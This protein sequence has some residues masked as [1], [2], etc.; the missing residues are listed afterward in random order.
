MAQHIEGKLY[1]ERMGRSGPVMAFVH[2]NP[3]DQSCWI[4]QMAH[5]SSWYRCIA[6]DIPGYGRSPKAIAGL[7]LDDMAEACW[8]AIDDTFPGESAILVGCSVGSIVLPHLYHL[9]PERTKA[10]I[11]S[12]TGYNPNKDFAQ[13][14][15]ASYAEQGVAFRWAYTFEDLSPAFR[16]TSLAHYFAELF[17]ERNRW[18]DAETIIHQFRALQA[19]YPE[20]HFERI[21]C[22]ALILTGSE[23]GAHQS[24]FA[25]QKRIPQCALEILPGAG[26]ACYMEQPWLFDRFMIAFLKKNGLFAGS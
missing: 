9:R 15:I 3:M 12:G 20:G 13:R 26:H 8:E 10:L 1:Y 23:D 24:A 18:A 4:F 21:R 22:P 5:F 11:L 6:I 17:T 14:R 7:T 2:P 16:A 19:P 25:L